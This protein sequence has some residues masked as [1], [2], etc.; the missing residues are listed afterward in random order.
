METKF[1]PTQNQQSKR[2]Q[3][4]KTLIVGTLAVML[5]IGLSGCDSTPQN[6]SLVTG[7][8]IS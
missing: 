6:H 5:L 2:K 7:V 1:I 8:D 3:K 4:M